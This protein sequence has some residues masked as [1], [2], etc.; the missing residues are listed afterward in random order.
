M[1]RTQQ[2]TIAEKVRHRLEQLDDCDENSV[3]H[4]LDLTQQEYVQK[5]ELLD[6]E[7]VK[8]WNTDQRVKALKI[9]IQCAK[10]LADTSVM[11]FYPSQFVLVTDVLDNFGRLV[12]ERLRT[13]AE[14]F[15][16]VF[17]IVYLLRIVILNI[18]IIDLAAQ[19]PHLCRRTLPRTW[20]QTRPKRLARIGFTKSRR[21]VIYFLDYTLK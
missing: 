9:A 20:S 15:M 12:F 7:L 11:Q 16:W 2:T 1:L 21:F 3:H 8:A 5:I 13:K 17:H 18:F 6:Q 14:Y 10:L 19:L 4:M